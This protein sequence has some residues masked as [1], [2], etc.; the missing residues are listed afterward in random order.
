MKLVL[1]GISQEDPETLKSFVK[2][3]EV[4]YP[5]AS[6]TDLPEPFKNLQAIPTTFFID[7]KGVIQSVTVGSR[8]YAQ[9]RD[10]ALAKDSE[11]EPK[12]EP[13]PPPWHA[14][15]GSQPLAPRLQPASRNRRV[16]LNPGGTGLT[17]SP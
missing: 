2:K 10:L 1:V 4:N 12:R 5:I 3:K 14:R 11:G 15:S 13:A 8:D 7:R 6:A 17:I 16:A 9:L